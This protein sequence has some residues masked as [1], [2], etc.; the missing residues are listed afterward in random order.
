MSKSLRQKIRHVLESFIAVF[1]PFFQYIPV[2]G[3]W[4]GLMSF[5]L[6]I[7]L[8]SLLWE[9]PEFL[10]QEMRLL[11]FS[12]E[13]MFG[14]IV[15]VMGFIIFLAA[16]ITLLRGRR[17]IVTARIY[18][19]VRHPQYLGLIIMT[20]GVSIMCAQYQWGVTS[21]VLRSWSILAFV[22][23]LLAWYEER[24][25]LKEYEK[26]YQEYRQKVPF[27][28]PIPYPA[29]IPQPLFTLV[30]VLIFGFSLILF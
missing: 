29:K 27:M 13:L 10:G 7:Y 23:I 24:H 16:L 17:E 9:Y 18:S 1:L 20:W 5:P 12:R 14:R 25:L 8:F 21:T 19:K 2:V 3:L 28:F 15:A 30:I 4:C 6:I 22:Y 11:F 26:E